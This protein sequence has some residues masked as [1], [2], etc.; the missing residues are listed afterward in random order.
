MDI[1]DNIKN[2]KFFNPL[3]GI[4]KRIYFECISELIE[5]AKTCPVLYE[6]DLR[7]R[8]E[9]YLINK[10]YHVENDDMEF[11][12]DEKDSAKI[13]R[14]FRECG[15]LTK[16]ELGRNGEYITNITS[17]C[18]KIIDFLNRLN[19]RKS[20]ASISNRILSMYE[21]LQSAYS[22][23]S[24]RKDRPYSSIISPLMDDEAELKNE[25]LDLKEDVSK[26]L[27]H[28]TEINDLSS[29]GKYLLGDQHL[30]KLF[31]DYF[32]M[33]ND[34]LIPTILK[35]IADYL[36]RFKSD[37]LFDKAINE[38]AEK[39]DINKEEARD[40]LNKYL[41]EMFYYI[42]KEYPDSMDMIDDS[43]NKYYRLAKMRLRL[44][45]SNGVNLQSSID[46]LLTTLKE[47]NTNDK[48]IIIDKLRDCLNINSQ[49][50][51]SRRS[52]QRIRRNSKNNTL[53]EIK[54]ED[55]SEEE[56]NRIT[57]ELLEN[58]INHYS[59]EKVNEYFDKLFKDNNLSFIKSKDIQNKQE[60]LMFI[61]A[62]IYSS[63]KEFNYEV[64]MQDTLEK[65]GIGDISNMTIRR[66]R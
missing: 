57:N 42:T 25:I 11:S 23:N 27:S 52:Y 48:N 51:I 54:L 62:F 16:P 3:T 29:M 5:Y 63:E 64:A 43:F 24:P 10:Q 6:N 9:L 22:E 65:T 14:K 44:I 55:I 46:Y 39:M 34:G 66:K 58:S 56:R 35:E 31:N 38:Y 21:I 59:L 13:I 17:S 26:V 45:T 41:D 49:K 18:R 50:Y 37:A 60:A 4:N 61:S 47:S 53:V 33:K 8:L 7:D 1:F 28:I 20:D 40:I 19:N 15:W 32:F 36:R 12:Y 2:E 30:E